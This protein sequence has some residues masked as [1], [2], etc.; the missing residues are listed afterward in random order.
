MHRVDKRTE[1]I[2][3]DSLGIGKLDEDPEA[4]FRSADL[5]EISELSQVSNKFEEGGNYNKAKDICIFCEKGE[6]ESPSDA[7]IN[8]I[9][10]LCNCNI[11]SHRLC[12]KQFIV[13]EKLIYCP[14]CKLPYQTSFIPLSCL[15]TKIRKKIVKYILLSLTMLIL[16]TIG[17]IVLVNYE[18]SRK[19]KWLEIIFYI[20]IC[21]IIVVN[22]IYG[23]LKIYSA[24][25][26][27][28]IKIICMSQEI[29]NH[30]PNPQGVFQ[31]YYEML[32]KEL[33]QELSNYVDQRRTIPK[34]ALID[35]LR[36]TSPYEQKYPL[37][38]QK[39]IFG[40]S[41]SIQNRKQPNK[42]T[43]N[44]ILTELALNGNRGKGE[45]KYEYGVKVSEKKCKEGFSLNSNVFSPSKISRLSGGVSQ[46]VVKRKIG[47]KAGE[48]SK[49]S[50]SKEMVGKYQMGYEGKGRKA[51]EH[52]AEAEAGDTGDTGESRLEEVKLN[53]SNG[54]QL[55]GNYMEE[56]LN[57]PNVARMYSANLEIL[58]LTSSLGEVALE[59]CRS[60]KLPSIQEATSDDRLQ[61]SEKLETSDDPALRK[62]ETTR[63][64]IIEDL[65]PH[66]IA[67]NL[68]QTTSPRG[69]NDDGNHRGNRHKPYKSALPPRAPKEEIKRDN[70][71]YINTKEKGS[72]EEW[73]EASDYKSTRRGCKSEGYNPRLGLSITGPIPALVCHSKLEDNN[74]NMKYIKPNTDKRVLFT[75]TGVKS[76][77]KLRSPP[78]ADHSEEIYGNIS[79]PIAEGTKEDVVTGEGDISEEGFMPTKD[80]QMIGAEYNIVDHQG[81]KK[82]LSREIFGLHQPPSNILGSAREPKTFG[83]ALNI[84]NDTGGVENVENVGNLQAPSGFKF[85]DNLSSILSGSKELG[86]KP[87]GQ[88]IIEEPSSNRGTRGGSEG[89]AKIKYILQGLESSREPPDTAINMGPH[90]F[91]GLFKSLEF[92]SIQT[93]KSKLGNL[94]PHQGEDHNPETSHDSF[95]IT[96]DSKNINPL[97]SKPPPNF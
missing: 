22:V 48:E 43:K 50:M 4:I 53:L 58:S 6:L 2:M 73:E 32:D 8:S 65:N 16:G 36:K 52:L 20:L 46:K 56:E 72:E 34:Y 86:N 64:R 85:P 12:A 78:P 91:G 7:D 62:P 47:E 41:R 77:S 90:T 80:I 29:S 82:G 84:Y 94:I 74:H 1:P 14:K 67:G 97:S 25:H 10:T 38:I 23:G 61:E 3:P 28:E 17:I 21:S 95:H 68:T 9:I 60:F 59:G 76:Q 51:R 42:L 75:Q 45:G 37:H 11:R 83:T 79:S 66:I 40:A 92:S 18:F 26:Y 27:T 15:N 71:V 63:E 55:E 54:G 24:I 19:I 39:Q 5:A 89:Y 57:N 49:C 35:Y 33:E 30:H 13:S 93:D 88:V 87:G 96:L 31:R 69:Y 81:E 44:N 70:H